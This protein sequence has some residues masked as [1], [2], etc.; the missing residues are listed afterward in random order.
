M[1]ATLTDQ[2]FHRQNWSY[3][4]KYDGIRI[5][6]YKE[7]ARVTLL[8]RNAKDRTNDFPH[9]AQTLRT[10][11]V[12]TLLLDGEIV[13]F[14]KKNVSHFQLLQQ[15]LG[16]PCYAVFDCLFANGQDLRKEKL[17]VRRAALERWVRPTQSLRISSQLSTNGHKAFQIAK[18]RKL[19]G[20]VAKNLDSIYS[21]R[22]SAEWLKVKVVKEEEFVIGGFTQPTGSRQ[23]FGALLLG[24]YDRGQLQYAG[25]VGS[26]FDRAALVSLSRKFRPLIRATSPF[27]KPVAEKHA[28]YLSP[29]LVAQT[30]FTEWTSDG[31]LRHPVYLGLRDDKR[32]KEVT[33]R[34][35]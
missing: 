7:N 19:E 9:I 5:L 25:K 12:A 21:E 18:R 30:S 10:L 11:K 24:I 2:P 29:Q 35:V 13:V 27:S 17:S 3:E 23:H 31:K 33:R 34:E 14:D 22:R 15:N 4:E 6:A 16:H 28:T 1:L 32:A 26:G 8:S 20:I